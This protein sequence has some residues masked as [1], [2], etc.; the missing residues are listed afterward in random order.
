MAD[1][2]IY[3]N[4]SSSMFFI[5]FLCVSFTFNNMPFISDQSFRWGGPWFSKSKDKQFFK[6]KV[7][8]IYY[9]TC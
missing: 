2:N 4:E 3:K 5:S 1:L 6:I 7:C 8:E 9:D